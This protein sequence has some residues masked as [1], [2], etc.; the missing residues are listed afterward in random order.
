[1]GNVTEPIELPINSTTGNETIPIPPIDV[2]IPDNATLPTQ[3]ETEPAQPSNVTSPE[4]VSDIIAELQDRTTALENQ[5]ASRQEV[6]ES[7]GTA[8]EQIGNAV[9]IVPG[10]T[11]EEQEAVVQSVNEVM[12]AIKALG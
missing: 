4:V 6:V 10:L 1:M 7:V 9:S 12:Q 11:A 5:S 2:E 3:N 8:I